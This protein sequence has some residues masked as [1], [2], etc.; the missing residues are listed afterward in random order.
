MDENV[1]T[2]AEQLLDRTRAFVREE[3]LPGAAV[4]VVGRDGLAWAG[5]AGFA[6]LAAAR[7]P[8]ADT[9]YRIASN[10]KVFTAIGVMQLRDEGR[11]RLDDPL[12]VHLPEFA[13]VTNPFGPD[14]GRDHPPPPDARVGPAGGAPVHRPH[15][16]RRTAP[17]AVAR[18]ARQRAGR[19]PAVQRQQV[20]QPRLR[21]ARRGRGASQRRRLRGGA[22]AARPA[23]AGDGRHHLSSHG[24]PCGPLRG[25][26][27]RPRGLRRA[28]ARPGTRPGPHARVRHALVDGRR[29]GAL[30][31]LRHDRRSLE[32]R[33]PSR[34]LAAIPGRDAGL[35]DPHRRL[36]AGP[37]GTRLVLGGR[38]RRF[39]LAGPRRRRARLHQPHAVPA[40][41]RRRRRSS[42]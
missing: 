42:C 27:R 26:L 3:R 7:R 30:P 39:S 15:A 32:R 12:V 41:G 18:G 5:A 40:R 11:L 34:A 31:R 9:P 16:T 25:G 35:P 8:D 23:T 4:G 19:D 17:R 1:A 21:P 38:T 28:S 13:Q 10:T 6:D 24:G 2:V 29:P 14:R 36:A 20:L 37:S 33:L 22:A